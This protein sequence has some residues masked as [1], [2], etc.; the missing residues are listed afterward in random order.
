MTSHN[1]RDGFVQW[2]DRVD[3]RISAICGLSSMDLADQCWRD[4]YDDGMSPREAAE[5]CLIDEGFPF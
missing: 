4:W 1:T 3:A 2:M 5:E